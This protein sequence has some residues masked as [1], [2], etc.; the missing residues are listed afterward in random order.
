MPRPKKDEQI[1]LKKIEEAFWQLLEEEDYPKMTITRLSRL[2]HINRNTVYYHFEDLD[3]L[4]R[5]IVSKTVNRENVGIFLKS[6]LTYSPE[7]PLDPS[8]LEITAKIHL[9]AKSQAPFVR[10]LLENTLI[11][12]W[13]EL[14]AIDVQALNEFEQNIL[15]FCAAGITSM[16][17][18]KELIQNPASFQSFPKSLVGQALLQTIQT[19]P[20]RKETE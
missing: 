7:N 15:R 6:L 11:D 18:R 4:T 1:A 8:L 9:L 2:S 10:E 14:F 17:A 13:T 16:L 19:F 3:M 20:K 5:W 12:G